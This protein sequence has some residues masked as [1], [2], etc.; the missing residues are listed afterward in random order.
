VRDF[1]SDGNVLCNVVESAYVAA[2]QGV[3]WYPIRRTDGGKQAGK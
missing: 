1:T 3:E 2:V